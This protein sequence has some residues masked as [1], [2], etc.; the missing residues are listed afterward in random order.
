M[1]KKNIRKIPEHVL[2]KIK[3][4]DQDDVVV[5]CV[6]AI[7]IEDVKKYTHLGLEIENGTLKLPK[8]IVPK[9]SAGKFSSA[10][11]YG[12]EQ[13]R[14]D[15]PK[16]SKTFERD[17]PDWGGYSTHAVSW[18]RDVYRIDFFPPKE[19]TI[20][21]ALIEEKNGSY[22]VRF[23]IEQ[24]INRRTDNFEQELY[25]N[26]NILQENVGAFNVF[27]SSMTLEEY[28]N[29]I[30]VDWEILPLGTVD[31]VVRRMLSG[32]RG[33]T[34]EQETTMFERINLIND[35]KPEYYVKGTD[36]FFRYFGAKFGDDFVAF[37]NIRYGNALYIMFN[38]WEELSQKSRVELLSGKED[39]FKRIVHNPGWEDKFI[40]I[41]KE[42][43]T[44]HT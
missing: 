40:K 28:K 9:A 36:D 11:V 15:L 21:T 33:V 17:L 24:V 2:D 18:D 22:I 14:R 37:E 3:T 10:N 41:V 23:A 31:E 30:S 25:Y 16:I 42:Y 1:A 32:T 35:L 19:V 27:I 8:E 26:L 7:K 13:K 38:N 43:K 39:S 5:A 20:S 29:T 6:K 4:F 34:K 12:Y 44:N